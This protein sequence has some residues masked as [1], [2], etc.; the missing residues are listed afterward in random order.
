MKKRHHWRLK[1]SPISVIFDKIVLFTQ[2]LWLT[3]PQ[4][5]AEL[6]SWSTLYAAVKETVKTQTDQSCGTVLGNTEPIGKQKNIRS[7]NQ[8]A[9]K[10]GPTAA[11]KRVGSDVGPNKPLSWGATDEKFRSNVT[12]TDKE[13]SFEPFNRVIR[14]IQ[15]GDVTFQLRKGFTRKETIRKSDRLYKCIKMI[16][17]RKKPCKYFG[18]FLSYFTLVSHGFLLKL[19]SCAYYCIGRE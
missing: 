9:V 15:R 7:S 18:G 4:N 14:E 2:T 12:A 13:S 1:V 8:V 3:C 17:F 11:S 6:I 5:Y 19:S 16:S 10:A